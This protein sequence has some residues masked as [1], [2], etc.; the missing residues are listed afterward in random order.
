VGFISLAKNLATKEDIEEITRK[1]EQVKT[2]KTSR[3]HI[4]QTRYDHEFKLL[5][6]LSDKLVNAREA[7]TGL[8]PETAYD[9]INDPDVRKARYG[10]YID[11]AKDLYLFA[12]TRQPFLPQIIYDEL[13]RLDQ[14][15]WAEAVQQRR[16]DPNKP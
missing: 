13:K 1:I 4:H 12:E 6:E 8:R 11:A 7:A 9:D 15:T 5:L 14:V 10:R 3:L 2:S 16:G